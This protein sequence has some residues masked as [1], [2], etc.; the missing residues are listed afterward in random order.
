MSD[1]DTATNTTG[2]EDVILPLVTY[3]TLANVD[4]AS[5]IRPERTSRKLW[6]TIGFRASEPTLAS[7]AQHAQQPSRNI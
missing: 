5:G 7:T 6:P 3:V 1:N 2:A 4:E